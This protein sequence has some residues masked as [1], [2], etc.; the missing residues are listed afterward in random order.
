MI[1]LIFVF[2]ALLVLGFWALWFTCAGKPLP[3]LTDPAV[4]EQPRWKPYR[5]MILEGRRWLDTQQVRPLQV[6]SYDGKMLYGRFVPCENARGTILLF[7]GYRST[8][9]VDFSIALELYH[10][11]G[12]N[13]LLC[14]QRANGLSQGCF[15]TFGAKE[16]YDVLS[17]VTYLSLMLGE[18]HPMILDGMS[19]GATTVL[20]AS[21]MEFPGNVCGII[22]DSGF[23]CGADIVEYVAKTHYRLPP[24]LTA[25]FLNVFTNLFAGFSLRRCSA[26]DA[27]RHCNLPVLIIH[28]LDDEL[29]PASMSNAIYDAAAGRKVLLQVEGAGHGG[30]YV[31]D[32]PRCQKALWDF[33]NSV[34]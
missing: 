29:V 13:L 1:I 7:P 12:L 6:M 34:L 30:S 33:V 23:S 25:A 5:E 11:M 26:L 31:K 17:W 19:M 28:G 16:R 8:Y 24:K 27:V 2:L 21:E 15:I 20:L 9:A 22:A 10:S 14:D 4:L 3:D 32:K 18:D